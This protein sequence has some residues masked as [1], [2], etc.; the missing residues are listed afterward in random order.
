[1]QSRWAGS[2]GRQPPGPARQEPARGAEALVLQMHGME[3]HLPGWS[4]WGLT[5]RVSAT[6]SFFILPV[7]ESET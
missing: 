7:S 4:V 3:L 6:P 2:L 5:P 1:M